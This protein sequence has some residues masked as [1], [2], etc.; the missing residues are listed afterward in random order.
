MM[1]KRPI[2]RALTWTALLAP[3][4]LAMGTVGAAENTAPQPPAQPPPSTST[5]QALLSQGFEVKNVFL[6][7][8]VPRRV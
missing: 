4:V 6:I 7:S 8:T 5:Y 2:M 1:L 3:Y